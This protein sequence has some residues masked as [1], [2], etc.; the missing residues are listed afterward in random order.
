M[1]KSSPKN[2]PFVAFAGLMGVG[3][4]T[5]AE[6]LVKHLGLTPVYEQY[7][8]NPYLKKFYQDKKRWAYQSQQWFLE[9]K[10][11][12]M[13]EIQKLLDSPNHK[14]VI[15]DMAIYQDA[16]FAHNLFAQKFMSEKNWKSYE[17]LLETG[18]KE[19]AKPI[20]FHLTADIPTI[21]KRIQ[22]RGREYEKNVDAKYLEGLKKSLMY[23]LNKICDQVTI[24]EFGTEE[25][26]LLENPK[27]RAEFIGFAQQ[28]LV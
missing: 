18:C 17:K 16:A 21:L 8:D 26:E 5:R 19:M 4:T 12:Q 14:G 28:Y 25:S 24:V 3:K 11:E 13:T 1:A 27:Q 15:Q 20:I 7:G 6:L 23:W 10:L 22:K 9:K 2:K